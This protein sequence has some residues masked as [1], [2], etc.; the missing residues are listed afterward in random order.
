[1]ES[2]AERLSRRPPLRRRPREQHA[3][4][5]GGSDDPGSKKIT[6]PYSSAIVEGPIEWTE[7]PDSG[8][9]VA[10]AIPGRDDIKILQPRRLYARQGQTDEHDAMVARLKRE[11]R[12]FL[13]A[14]PRPRRV[15]REIAG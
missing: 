8:Y 11:R 1:M 15:P 14:F 10:V 5:V 9:Q 7:D 12:D 4:S 2:T 3:G 6:I 13:N